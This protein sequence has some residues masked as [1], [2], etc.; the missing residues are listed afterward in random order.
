[1][2]ISKDPKLKRCGW[3]TAMN[4]PLYISYH[5][6]E[7]GVP[8]HDD[9]KIFE[10][11]ILE[12]AQAGLS[13]LTVLRKRQSYREAFDGFDFDS[14]ANYDSKKVNQLLR[15][16]GIIRNKVKIASAIKNANAVLRIRDEFGSFDKYIWNFVP[17]GRPLKNKR[18]SLTDIPAT[19]EESDSLSKDL[20]QRGFSFVGSTICYA[21]MQAT[22]MVN[23][24]ILSCF[25]YNEV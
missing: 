21:H 14:V 16:E 9:K 10:F 8:V 5:D 12:G 7:W 2:A 13:W 19:S 1:M 6:L 20:Y 15:N 11:L 4:D 22:G 24:H 25:R 3:S 17:E 18:K 23:D